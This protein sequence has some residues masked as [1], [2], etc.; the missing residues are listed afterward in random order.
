MVKTDEMDIYVVGD[1]D[2]QYIEEAITTLY[3]N[4]IP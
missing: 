1:M 4:E 2:P 3:L